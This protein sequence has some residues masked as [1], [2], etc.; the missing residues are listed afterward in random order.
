MTEKTIIETKDLTRRFGK[1]AAVN[2]LDLSVPGGCVY[3]FLG[4]NG[5]GKT[6]TIRM[7]LGLLRPDQ[8]TV[9]LFGE[10]LNGSR[11]R[12][13]RKVGSLVESPSLYPN[14]TGRE[15]LQLYGR[16]LGLDDAEVDRVL[17][18][19]RMTGAA[20]RLVRGYS[21]GMRQRIGL[22]AALL[23]RPSL[24][25]LDEPTSG[26]D[27]AGI[28]EM[29]QLLQGLPEAF[30][31]T[32]FLS[33]HLL[34]EVEQVANRIGIIHQGQ[35]VFQGSPGSLQERLGG[36]AIIEV[37]K[38][39]RACQILTGLGWQVHRNGGASLSL[40]S[41]DAL[42]LAQANTQ[43][44]MQGINVLRLSQEKRSLEDIFLTLTQSAQAPHE[45]G[46]LSMNGKAV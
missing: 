19:V 16:L 8:G 6:T 27:P 5:A 10:A 4:P 20:E 46:A 2:G 29:R 38:P 22:A 30:G 40:V 33:S 25:I 34:N 15:T 28:L 45:A 26:L 32:I 11:Q 44:V 21:T 23:G 31:V 24:L 9:R 18:I 12:V 37:D 42:T 7:L 39:D 41:R 43:L 1:V 35:L 36:S 13:L 17:D 3:G 14:L